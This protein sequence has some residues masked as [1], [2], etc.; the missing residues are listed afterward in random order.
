[1][2][3]SNFKELDAETGTFNIDLQEIA[4]SMISVSNNCSLNKHNILITGESHAKGY[5]EKISSVLGIAFD[6]IGIVKPN[7]DLETVTSFVK[8]DIKQLTKNDDVI[9]CGG[10]TNIARNNSN[11]GFHSLSHFVHKISNTNV[12]IM[13]VP[14]RF[15]LAAFSCVNEE[16]KVFSSRLCKLLKIHKHIQTNNISTYKQHCITHGL[17]KNK[18]GK[19]CSVHILARLIICSVHILARL[20]KKIFLLN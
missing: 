10:S 13:D 17:H 16:V 3:L 7:S 9:V 2:L 19:E 6:V 15:D 1:V 18:S 11:K 12:I 5:L 20:I 8:S 14:N 4:V